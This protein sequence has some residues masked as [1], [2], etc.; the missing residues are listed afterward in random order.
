MEGITF[1]EYEERYK[2]L[3]QKST[4]AFMEYYNKFPDNPSVIE[5]AYKAHISSL[6][7]DFRNLDSIQ[8]IKETN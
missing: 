6:A 7:S 8:I 4:D 3:I 2:K 5:A 1:K